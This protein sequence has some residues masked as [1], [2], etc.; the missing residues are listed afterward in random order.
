MFEFIRDIL[1]RNPSFYLQKFLKNGHHI[2]IFKLHKMYKN[3]KN[4]FCHNINYFFM[5][6]FQQGRRL[7]SAETRMIWVISVNTSCCQGYCDPQLPVLI[8]LIPRR[9]I[10]S[11]LLTGAYIFRVH[12]YFYPPYAKRFLSQAF[13]FLFIKNG[14]FRGG[15]FH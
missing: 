2:N 11:T 15:I 12:P 6:S 14:V 1:L 5:K 4:I 10:F 7:I 13:C 9:L 8:L 3:E